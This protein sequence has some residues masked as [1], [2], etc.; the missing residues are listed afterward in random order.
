MDAQDQAQQA[1]E[2]VSASSNSL[3]QWAPHALVL[4]LL[5]LASRIFM[6]W[7]HRLDMRMNALERGKADKGESDSKFSDLAARMNT[8]DDRLAGLDERNA[9]RHA[10]STARMD[11]ILFELTRGQNAQR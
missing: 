5:A 2:A 8:I 1:V 4:S 7:T 9:Q 10:E 6:R 3:W 11:R